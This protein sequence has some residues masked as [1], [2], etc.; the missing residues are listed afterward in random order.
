MKKRWIVPVVAGMALLFSACSAAS[1]SKMSGLEEKETMSSDG[2]VY[3][4]ITA[5]EGKKMM[6]EGNV[7]VVD[8]RTSEEF[9]EEHIPDAINIPNETIGSEMPD[10]LPDKD[11]ALIVYCRTGVRSKD[12]SEKLEKLGYQ[13]IYDIGGIVDWPYQTKSE[14]VK[15]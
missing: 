11:T 14:K 12:A 4:K 8:V 3:H 7:T 10:A 2:A 6:D 15:G 13:K 5:E 1:E 9:E